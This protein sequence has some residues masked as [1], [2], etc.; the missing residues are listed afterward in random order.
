MSAYG[1]RTLAAQ[2]TLT[3]NLDLNFSTTN[4][5]AGAEKI[6][7]NASSA[8]MHHRQSSKHKA[9]EE[10]KAGLKAALMKD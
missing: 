4:T 9:Y 6:S 1:T 7:Q 3:Y 5:G 2:P 10:S 8:A